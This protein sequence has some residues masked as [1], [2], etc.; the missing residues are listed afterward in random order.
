MRHHTTAE[1]CRDLPSSRH[2]DQRYRPHRQHQSDELDGTKPFVEDEASEE[3]SDRRIE[4]GQRGY[5]NEHSS[6]EGR[7]NKQVGGDVENASR[8]AGD[9]TAGSRDRPKEQNE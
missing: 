5:D 7:Q 8:S 4:G 6:V 3:H 9:D 2:R 1:R